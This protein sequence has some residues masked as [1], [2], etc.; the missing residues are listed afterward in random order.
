MKTIA[1]LFAVVAL[2]AAQ[3]THHNFETRFDHFRPQDGRVANFV[4]KT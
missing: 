4:S 3:L 2:A 1:V